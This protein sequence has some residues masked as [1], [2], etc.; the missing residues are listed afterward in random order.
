MI[1]GLLLVVIAGILAGGC[2][3]PIKIMRRFGYAHWALVSQLLG[4]VLLPWLAT[5]ILC[6]HAWAAYSSVS[7]MVVLKA[8]I[9]SLAWGVAN[10]LCGLCLV[11]IGFS[12]TVGLLTG[13]G[14]PLGVLIPMIF[15]GTGLFASSPGM[16]SPSG[17]IV[18]AGVV[19]M[20]FAVALITLA[21]FGR[22]KVLRK[23]GLAHGASFMAGLL[24][25]S[26]AGLLQVGLSFAFVYSQGP[27]SEAL[28]ARGAGAAAAG[29]GV[30]ALTLPGGALVNLAFPAWLI[31]RS[32]SW[33]DFRR[34]PRDIGLSALMGI[35]FF[36]FVL[37]MG[38]GMRFL[39]ALGAS[40]GF[41]IYQAVQISSSQAVGFASG[42][43]RGIVG[44]PLRQM[45]L[46][47][48]LLLAAVATMAAG[49]ATGS[50]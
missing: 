39:G 4:L 42:E 17:H 46:A 50:G 28:A 38:Q 48:V 1:T 13:I 5:L 27:I 14:L 30:W 32:R 47:L 8:N 19:I 22:D 10:V 18:L 21:G 35:M 31:T 26:V 2:A 34:C 33:G 41:G 20:L 44:T 36:L 6:P 24:M 23:Q 11:R 37:S 9:F 16:A 15:R 45:A 40:I 7:R 29:L 25:A 49:R 3:A 12:L 43:W